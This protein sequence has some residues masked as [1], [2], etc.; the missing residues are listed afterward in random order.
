[1]H[2][3]RA[4]PVTGLIRGRTE[5][6]A[7]FMSRHGA[8]GPRLS[9]LLYVLGRTEDMWTRTV[10]SA[11]LAVRA[12]VRYSGRACAHVL[13]CTLSRVWGQI[14]CP[15]PMRYSRPVLVCP[16]G[17][18]R[19]SSPTPR[20]ARRWAGWPPT[21]ADETTPRRESGSQAE[22]DPAAASPAYGHLR[23]MG[24]ER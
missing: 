24:S 12:P 8:F 21:G 6:R 2:D 7:E 10:D 15:V 16:A 20:Q 9:S 13:I 5:D 17:C 18:W 22:T 11:R 1:M 23:T 14:A 4:E 19:L 3:S